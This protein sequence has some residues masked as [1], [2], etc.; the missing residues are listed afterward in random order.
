MGLVITALVSCKVHTIELRPSVHIRNR[1]I[2]VNNR[3]IIDYPF[4]INLHNKKE[5][6]ESNIYKYS[7]IYSVTVYILFLFKNNCAST[8]A[9]LSAVRFL[10]MTLLKICL[11][12]TDVGGGSQ[13]SFCTSNVFHFLYTTLTD[14]LS[15][16]SVPCL[17]CPCEIPLL[18]R[19]IPQ[20]SER[21]FL[22]Q[23]TLPWLFLT[24]GL[25]VTATSLLET[26]TET[27]P[28]NLT[29]Y[30]LL[31]CKYLIHPDWPI[32]N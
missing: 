9:G 14:L 20:S 12:A 28:A 24:S 18:R 6:K 19:W 8:T 30:C 5:T 23:E 17:P 11:L 3:L 31:L 29:H 26:S 4:E 7:E 2:V 21:I 22:H 27:R 15:I 13:Y 25:V 16:L 1:L 32:L 10:E